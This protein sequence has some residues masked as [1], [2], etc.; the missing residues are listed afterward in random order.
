MYSKTNERRD[1]MIVF[2]GTIFLLIINSVF[3]YFGAFGI[4][5]AI[6]GLVSGFVSLLFSDISNW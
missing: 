4:E 3:V 5:P 6:C 2:I 1:D